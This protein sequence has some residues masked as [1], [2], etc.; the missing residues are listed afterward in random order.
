VREAVR[1]RDKV[2]DAA[3]QD[4]ADVKKLQERVRKEETDNRGFS[5]GPQASVA[6]ST[7]AA[8]TTLLEAKLKEARLSLSTSGQ[9]RDRLV[10]PRARAVRM[11]TWPAGKESWALL[12][13]RG[14]LCALCAD[15]AERSREKTRASPEETGRDV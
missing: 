12:T 5:D 4:Q 9:A 14:S 6:L 3:I 8:W 2:K 11:S 13:H 7:L 10:S 1:E 15:A